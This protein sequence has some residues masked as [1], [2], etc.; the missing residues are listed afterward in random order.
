MRTGGIRYNGNNGVNK[1]VRRQVLFV[2]RLHQ[3][4]ATQSG[5]SVKK[6]NSRWLSEEAVA[7]FSTHRATPKVN[8]KL[9]F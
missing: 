8:N 6:R 5:R 1:G 3:R 9:R 4:P 7:V 2:S